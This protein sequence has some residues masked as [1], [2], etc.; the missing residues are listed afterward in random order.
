MYMVS[1]MNKK[2]SIGVDIGGTKLSFGIINDKGEVIYE[3]KETSASLDASEIL[4]T[5]KETL[6]VIIDYAKINDI[7]IS[8]IGIGSP[9]RISSE[10]GM[11]ID[12]TPN[13]KNWKGIELKK[14]L[15]IFDL[16]VF[17]DN[18]A[19][20]AALG[21]YFLLK[22][23][24]KS[25]K[26]II[27]LTIGTGLGSGVIT[28]NKLF[29]GSGLGC[30]IGHLIIDYKGRECNCGQK[31][32][33]EMY[34]SGTALETQAKNRLYKYPDSLL[35]GTSETITGYQIFDS[36]KK[37][38]IF[39]NLLIDEMGEILAYGIISLINIFDPD[40]ILISGGISLQKDFYMN[41]VRSIVKKELNY[42]KFD[43]SIIKI[44]QSNDKAG[45]IGSALLA[46]Q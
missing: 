30:E 16:P 9:G 39:A 26:T 13:L 27:V 46:L 44:A 22:D 6:G 45:L 2:Y 42:F 18:D 28:D 5:L 15:S 21:E 40:M 36:A 14:E 25:T 35:N 33:L 11:V 17:V 23:E 4:K 8:G 41:K 38:D 34:V 24:K 3:K 37:G 1:K 19:N 32:C 12:C 10:L 31:G 7:N 20:C 29:K 43:S